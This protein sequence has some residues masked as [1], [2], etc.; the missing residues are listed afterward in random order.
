MI[1][2]PYPPLYFATHL[3]T[4]QVFHQTPLTMAFTNLKPLIPGHTLVSPRRPAARLRDLSPPEISDL[5]NTAAKV[6]R[7]LERVF[8]SHGL[9]VAVQD[10]AAAGQTVP[11]VHCHVIPR[12]N[13]D[14]DEK[15]G[16]DRLYEM[17]EGEEGDVGGALRERDRTAGRARGLDVK[18]EERVPRGEEEMRREAE[19]LEGEMERQEEVE[20]AE[21]AKG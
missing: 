15:G 13:G 3:I 5:F 14:L 21:G 20:R 8:D 6:G 7:M 11:H 12:K 18:E 9:N 2:R 4:P 17:L 19:W 10:G 16:G 1:T